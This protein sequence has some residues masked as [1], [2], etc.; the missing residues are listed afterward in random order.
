VQN[1][2][3]N[4]GFSFIEAISMCPTY[5]GRKNKKGSAVNMMEWQKNSAVNISAASKL[6]PEAL[7]GKFLIGEFK[8]SPEPEYTS[9]YKKIIDKLE[10]ER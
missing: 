2:I 8:N 5:Y 1:A 6:S 9:E 3:N 10:K 4:E 7:E